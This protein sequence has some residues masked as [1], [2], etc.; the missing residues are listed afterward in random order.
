M[1]CCGK[2]TM[3]QVMCQSSPIYDVYEWFTTLNDE[4][5]SIM[6]GHL[7]GQLGSSMYLS[8]LH[9]SGITTDTIGSVSFKINNEGRTLSVLIFKNGKMKISGGFP[10]ALLSCRDSTI[11]DDYI[12]KTVSVIQEVTKLET[13]DTKLSCLNGQLST[14]IFKDVAQL[15]LF[16]KTKAHL[17]SKVRS[18]DFDLPGRRGAFKLY[19][20]KSRKTHIA[21]DIKGKSQIFATTSFDELFHLFKILT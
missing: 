15:A 2:P 11:M 7:R 4:H 20:H 8:E 21:I 5:K 1:Q 18:P 16:V 6:W 3:F 19:L 12:H 17:F 10:E 13:C 9:S 14:A